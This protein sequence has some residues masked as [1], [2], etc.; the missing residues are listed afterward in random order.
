[1]GVQMCGCVGGWTGFLP[2]SGFKMLQNCMAL[3]KRQGIAIQP[4][5]LMQR[6]NRNGHKVR[7]KRHGAASGP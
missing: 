3:G 2:Q 7:N 4:F 6:A 1:V 5:V